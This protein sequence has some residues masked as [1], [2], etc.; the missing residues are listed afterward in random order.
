MA[1]HKL[2]IFSSA[3]DPL[4]LIDLAQVSRH[5]F[6]ALSAFLAIT[7]RL[8]LPRLS[9]GWLDLGAGE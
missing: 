2:S 8:A 9:I 6:G 1:S 3:L 7:I 5:P 4:L